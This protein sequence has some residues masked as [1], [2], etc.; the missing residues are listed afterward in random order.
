[1]LFNNFPSSERSA[2]LKK[3]HKPDGKWVSLGQG[4]TYGSGMGSFPCLCVC[5]PIS[6]YGCICMWLCIS[7]CVS[8]YAPPLPFRGKG[9]GTRGK[10]LGL[11]R[12]TKRELLLLT[13]LGGRWMVSME[14]R[15]SLTS[16]HNGFSSCSLFEAPFLSRS[17]FP[18]FPISSSARHPPR[19]T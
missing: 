2:E 17:P 16:K 8:V 11:R 12:R 9:K 10:S 6:S 7:K 18:S 15:G 3:I 13:L 14:T 5:L 4:S 19:A 1:M